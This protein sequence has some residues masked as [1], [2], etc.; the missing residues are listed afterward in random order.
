MSCFLLIGII[1]V[2]V[3]ILSNQNTG[4]KFTGSSYGGGLGYSDEDEDFVEDL[5]SDGEKEIDVNDEEL[6]SYEDTDDDD[7]RLFF[8]E[9]DEEYEEDIELTRIEDDEIMAE[10]EE[11]LIDGKI[12]DNIDIQDWLDNVKERKLYGMRRLNKRIKKR[13][14]QEGF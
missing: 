11:L 9:D 14:Q 3:I 1:L 10:L 5:Y 7:D 12:L 4:N 2:V 13:L 6:L 8:E